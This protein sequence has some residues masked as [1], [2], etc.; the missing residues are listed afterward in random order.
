[1]A[2]LAGLQLQAH[3]LALARQ[4]QLQQLLLVLLLMRSCQ[5]PTA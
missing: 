1:M 3:L 2:Q 5:L 4:V